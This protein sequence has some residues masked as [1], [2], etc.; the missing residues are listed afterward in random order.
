MYNLDDER[1]EPEPR[2]FTH[3]YV[4]ASELPT[5][6]ITPAVPTTASTPDTSLKEAMWGCMIAST[7]APIIGVM[8]GGFIGFFVGTVVGILIG[9]LGAV[10][11]H[12]R[13]KAIQAGRTELAFTDREVNAEL[14]IG[15]VL[16]GL[17]AV[18]GIGMIER[19]HAH[20]VA[21]EIQRGRS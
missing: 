18:K 17:A 5:Q 21:E 20:L 8:A 6:P 1:F 15:A 14:A 19:H 16:V 12:K 4:P 11:R 2:L 3:E 10:V 13:I 9:I 7:A